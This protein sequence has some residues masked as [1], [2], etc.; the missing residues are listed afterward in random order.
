MPVKTPTPY[1]FNQPELFGISANFNFI[2]KHEK[3]NTPICF[4][5]INHIRY[6]VA[7]IK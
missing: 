3:I 7:W 1:N 5:K 4:P 2:D 6:L